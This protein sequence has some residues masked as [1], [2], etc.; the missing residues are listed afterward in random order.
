MRV[1]ALG[2]ICCALLLASSPLAAQN[3]ATKATP[4]DASERDK[5]QGEQDAAKLT[6][7]GD[8]ALW[9]VAIK[10]DKTAEFEQVLTKLQAALK[11]SA[12]PERRKQ[13]EGWKVLRLSMPLPDGNIAYVHVVQPV[14][15]GAGYGIMQ[16]LYDAFPEQRQELYESYRGAFVRNVALGVGSMVIDMNS[17]SADAPASPASPAAPPATAQPAAPSTAPSEGAASQR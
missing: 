2:G 16:I 9:T 17:G 3:A 6:F 10:A 5:Q 13:A 12:D 15:R 4:P 14:V 8:V 1:R 11:K 7:D